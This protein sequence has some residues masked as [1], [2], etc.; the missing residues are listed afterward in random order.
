MVI[1]F[2]L[3][4][5]NLSQ[6]SFCQAFWNGS[7]VTKYSHQISVPGISFTA[8]LIKILHSS[9]QVVCLMFNSGHIPVCAAESYFKAEFYYWYLWKSST[10]LTYLNIYIPSHL[11]WC[12]KIWHYEAR[13]GKVHISI[14]V[15]SITVKLSI[16]VKLSIT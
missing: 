7:L 5:T 13:V 2:G 15:N 16:S 3:P 10:K 4:S 9:D 8:G 14:S 6:I 11:M 12:Q 1:S